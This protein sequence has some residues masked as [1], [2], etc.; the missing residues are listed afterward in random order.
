MDKLVG[1]TDHLRRSCLRMTR[2]PRRERQDSFHVPAPGYMIF[3]NRLE[4]DA[5]PGGRPS[6]GIPIRAERVEQ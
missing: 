4:R 1:G 6:I 2:C 5:M 3:G